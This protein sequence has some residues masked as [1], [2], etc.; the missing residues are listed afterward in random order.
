M[1]PSIFLILV[2]VLICCAL[3]S[4]H[5]VLGNVLSH[6]IKCMCSLS[7]HCGIVRN[8]F[9]IPLYVWCRGVI[10]NKA[11]FDFDQGMERSGGE[12]RWLLWP[13]DG[14]EPHS[15]ATIRRTHDVHSGGYNVSDDMDVEV[16]TV[17]MQT[18]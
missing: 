10:D 13:Q 4:L 6:Q 12:V 8:V 14:S 3:Q 18:V 15:N 5:C 2:N 17:A 1:L 9:S 16:E 7:V 11:D